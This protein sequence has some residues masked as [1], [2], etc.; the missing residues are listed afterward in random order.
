MSLQKS[1]FGYVVHRVHV[2]TRDE[3][4]RASRLSTWI[5]IVNT[6]AFVDRAASNGKTGFVCSLL[7]VTACIVRK[8]VHDF[9]NAS[10]PRVGGA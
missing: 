10:H 7:V 6:C 3:T 4:V 2:V 8:F 9:D 5:L 1:D